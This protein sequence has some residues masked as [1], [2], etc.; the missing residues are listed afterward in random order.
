[1]TK[2]LRLTPVFTVGFWMI[3]VLL[4]PVSIFAGNVVGNVVENAVGINGLAVSPDNRQLAFSLQGDI[5]TVSTD[6]GAARRLTVHAADDRSPAFCPDGHTL[7]FSSNRHGNYDVYTMDSN[8]SE[9]RR[10]T[11]D[12]A[13]DRVTQFSPCGEWIIFESVREFREHTTWKVRRSGGQPVHLCPLE[14]SDGKLSPDG[15]MFVYQKGLGSMYRLGYR[16]PGARDL[17]L[18][19]IPDQ[20]TRRVTQTAWNEMFPAWSPDGATIYFVCDETGFHNIH[21]WVRHTEKAA[22]VTGFTSGLITDLV[23]SSSTGSLYFCKDS[24][25]WTIRHPGDEPHTVSIKVPADRRLPD[26][27]TIRFDTCSDISVSPDG[28]NLVIEHRGDLFALNRNTGQTT[29]LTETPFREKWP[30]WHPEKNQ[31]FYVSDR[32][33]NGEIY[34]L[35]P[36]DGDRQEFHKCRFFKETMVFVSDVPVEYFEISPDGNH[37]IYLTID[38][39]LII[40]TIDGKN[41]R[42]LLDGTY[43]LNLSVSPDSRWIAYL[44]SVHGL[45]TDTF[46]MDLSS[47]QEWNVSKLHG[48]DS[49]VRFSPD[50]RHLLITSG[51]QGDE[52]IYALWLSRADHERYPDDSD[53]SEETDGETDSPTQKRDHAIRP[54]D[55]K[56]EK[57]RADAV[58]PL[59]VDLENI[60]ERVRTIVEWPSADRMPIV[61]RDGKNLLFVS[62]AMGSPAVYAGSW[63]GNTLTTPRRL[64]EINPDQ[65]LW[66]TSNDSV[67]VRA[68]KTLATINTAG[69]ITPIRINGIM[70]VD[71][72]G[73]YYQMYREAW[74]TIKYQFYDPE[75]H[76]ADWDGA[77]QRY[78][79]WIESARTS[80]E[81]NDVIQR[82]IGE[83]NASHLDIYG[84]DDPDVP[85]PTTGRVGWKLGT[86]VPDRGYE[87]LDVVPDTPAYRTES[88][89]YPGET[90]RA[91]NRRVLTPETVV[92]E[93]LNDTAGRD[94]D[95]EVVSTGPGGTPRVVTLKPIEP[96][97]YHQKAYRFWVQQNREMV[98]RLSGGRIGYLHIQSMGSSSLERFRRELFGVQ[99]AKEAMIID[100]RG[101]PGGYIHNELLAHLSGNR[102]GWSRSRL[103]E[104]RDH[105]DY[106]WRKP[107]AVLIDERSFSDAEVFPNGYQRLGIGKVIGMPTFGGVIGTGGFH[108]LNGAWFRLPW[109]G[110]FTSD[111]R[112]MEN[113]G[114]VPDIIVERQ[115]AESIDNRDSQIERAVRELMANLP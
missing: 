51:Y 75:L 17:W 105:P 56:N 65:I 16:G 100:V 19:S 94:I 38:G 52:E 44:R 22:A 40:R 50:G 21:Q 79:P 92:A 108:L 28:K 63:D 69:T 7:A 9:P 84:G 67:I 4:H 8:G 106:V 85:G 18:Y 87:I 34:R 27:Q 29:P 46:L 102:F 5:W 23:C 71:R 11:F 107:S 112:N 10:I 53:E 3:T 83:L 49:S 48:Q 31:L 42:I 97:E 47:G 68:G 89:I 36:D 58:K 104:P 88:R 110:W 24:A 13:D 12:S 111:G 33:G 41:P 73:E 96:W 98:D 6:G 115:P 26:K 59:T 61:T 30:R 66:D 90:V 70:H 72:P 35:I 20:T 45:H 93:Y 14:S 81:F 37:L 113:T 101:N 1:M 43:V 95:I 114:A 54:A 99:M 57:K 62:D 91:I 39:Q 78:L 2:W 76:G 32:T 55:S 80:R 74:F 86:F 103:E 60:H 82:L 25:V 109:V 64:A 77:F 15:R